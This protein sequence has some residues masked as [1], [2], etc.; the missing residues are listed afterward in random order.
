MRLVGYE[1]M[2]TSLSDEK[3]SHF[4]FCIYLKIGH[5]NRENI[6]FLISFFYSQKTNNVDE[7][8]KFVEITENELLNKSKNY[9]TISSF[10][11]LLNLFR[12]NLNNRTDLLRKYPAQVTYNFINFEDTP[13]KYKES[14]NKL[15]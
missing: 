5:K 1:D 2:N 15:H 14:F 13:M 9:M 6:F 10:K 8:G 7:L 11:K 3:H 4:S 12:V